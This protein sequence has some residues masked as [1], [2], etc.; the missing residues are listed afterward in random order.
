MVPLPLWLHEDH[1]TC[2]ALPALSEEDAWELFHHRVSPAPGLRSAAKLV[3]TFLEQSEGLPGRFDAA[4]RAAIAVGLLQG[5]S[6]QA[7]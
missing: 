6:A 4:V 1:P 7:A 3:A 2:L 5:N